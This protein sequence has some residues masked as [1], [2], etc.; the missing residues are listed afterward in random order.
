MI[1]AA[2]PWSLPTAHAEAPTT[3]ENNGIAY[4]EVQNHASVDDCWVIIDVG[5]SLQAPPRKS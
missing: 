3:T 2:C 5:C 4:E 1:A